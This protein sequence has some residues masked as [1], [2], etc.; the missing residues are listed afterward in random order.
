MALRPNILISRRNFLRACLKILQLLEKCLLEITGM[1][2]I[3]PATGGGRA[4]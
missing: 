2:C 3:T 1:D 4:R